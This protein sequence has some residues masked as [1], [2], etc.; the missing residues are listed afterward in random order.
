V[1]KL[2][3]RTVFIR[4]L[5]R[6]PKNSEL[7]PGGRPV[8]RRSAGSWLG[9]T[10]GVRVAKGP[11]SRWLPQLAS[12]SH[13]QSCCGKCWIEDA[14]S[15]GLRPDPSQKLHADVFQYSYRVPETVC[16]NRSVVDRCHAL[17]S[18]D[19]CCP[20]LRRPDCFRPCD[21]LA[22]WDSHPLKIADFTAY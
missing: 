4:H 22:G 5:V 16:L 6:C 3:F 8:G 9:L 18:F 11:D 17:M 7:R 12:T 19:T 10:S 13:K 14:A 1:Q 21:R 15:S 20:F 2:R